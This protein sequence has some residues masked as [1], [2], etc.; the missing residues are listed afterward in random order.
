MINF[1]VKNVTVYPMFNL[2]PDIR[3]TSILIEVC[4]RVCRS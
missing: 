4:I 3:L 1:F 2:L